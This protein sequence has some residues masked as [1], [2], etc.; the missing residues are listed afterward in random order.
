MHR[1]SSLIALAL[2]A[3]SPACFSATVDEPT[4][5]DV[6][7]PFVDDGKFAGAVV[8][9]VSKD[10]VLDVEAVGYAD[11]ENRKP[12]RE[13][14]FFWIAS[15]SKPF[16]ATALM[17]LVDAG[18]VR[19]DD[20]VR[21]YLPNFSPRIAGKTADGSDRLRDPTQPVTVRM[22]LNHTHGLTPDY[23]ATARRDDSIPLPALLD[24]YLSRPLRHEPGAAFMYS[25]A[26]VNTAARIVEVVSGQ[27]FEVFIQRRLL[28]PLGMAETTYFPSAAQLA[29]LAL[30]Y[31]IPPETKTLAVTPLTALTYPLGDRKSRFAPAGA[32]FSTARD[33]GKF[34]QM[35]L[36]KGVLGGRRYLSEE[37]VA[38]MTRN[39]VLPPAAQTLPSAGGLDAPHGYGLGWGV[40][41]S[42][43]FFHPGMGTV[44]VR[45]DPT[46]QIGIV[47]L[48]QCS[49]EWSFDI[50]ARV[51]EAAEHRFATHR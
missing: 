43:A 9:V 47:F 35:F 38:E 51:M 3:A 49:T 46:R 2:L 11:V 40:G 7:Q 45:I 8:M 48:P 16:N 31:W 23:S 6:I 14:T 37:A 4:I 18:K 22:L 28:R 33:L 15:T 41:G 1:T 39:Q 34:A 12:M 27:S 36:N 13:D 5:R 26:G 24:D 44:D 21:K 29:R 32:L 30:S 25:D 42:G 10:E 20:P 17:M 19:L 50:R